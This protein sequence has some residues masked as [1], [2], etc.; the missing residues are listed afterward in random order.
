MIVAAVAVSL[1]DR[2]NHTTAV[3]FGSLSRPLPSSV[4]ISP[5]SQ[6]YVT[7]LVTDARDHFGTVGVNLMPLAVV[8]AG[9]PTV[10]IGV[11]RGCSDFRPST[12]ATIPVPANVAL[13][14]SSD[15]PLVLYQPSSH[16]DWELWRVTHTGDDWAACWG[17]KM[18]VSSSSPEAIPY[19]YGMAASGIPYLATMITDT[20]I[21]SGHIDHAIALQM[22]T[23]SAPPVS[24]ANRTDCGHDL[25][26]PP[27]GTRFR[28]PRSLTMPTSL[29]PFARMV[30][31]A[32]QRYGLIL[33]DR[34]GDVA[35]IAEIPATSPTQ[36]KSSTD[37][38]F[39]SWDGAPE[40]Q[41]VASLP[42]DRLVA[43]SEP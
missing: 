33:T 11:S 7:D 12:G 13:T 14:G 2:S 32:V 27:Y 18:Q 21:A 41:V 17:G 1:I 39:R 10:P 6:A 29:T 31:T 35:I 3:T 5:Q 34:S 30:F 19:P 37:A 25:G 22:P 15:N 23:C 20:D 24:P 9:Q 28:F 36:T 16:T 8:P 26:Q 43:V 42:W 38:I 40:Y 4:E